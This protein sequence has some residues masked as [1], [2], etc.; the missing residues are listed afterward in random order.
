MNDYL[1]FGH[2]LST[3][4]ACPGS[5]RFGNHWVAMHIGQL[6]AWQIAYSKILQI[7]RRAMNIIFSDNEVFWVGEFRSSLGTG[8]Q[9]I[10]TKQ[11]GIL[12]RGKC[13]DPFR[14][15]REGFYEEFVLTRD[16]EK[17][18]EPTGRSGIANRKYRVS[19]IFNLS[20]SHEPNNCRIPLFNGNHNQLYTHRLNYGYSQAPM[21]SPILA[22]G[23]GF[24]SSF[25]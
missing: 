1:V 22:L 6:M 7:E 20:R 10:T 21:F 18:K 17:P 11:N 16:S 2:L 19:K 3:W 24:K 25:S 23:H 5:E 14:R 8:L 13:S 4:N 15:I 12:R 9:F